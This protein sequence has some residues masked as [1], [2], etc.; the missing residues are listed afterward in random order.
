MG[1]PRLERRC[2]LID[3]REI[4][5][6]ASELSLALHVVEKD[7]VLGWLLAGIASHTELAASWV[8][9]G[10]TCVKKCYF[11]TYR[12]SEDLD[13]TVTD[14]SQLNEYYLLNAFREIADWIYEESGIAIPA[15]QIRF[16]LSVFDGGR[17]AEVRV[18]Y[19]GPL[20]QKRNLA[21]IK[22]DLTSKERLVL[23]PQKRPV[24]HPYSDRPAAGIHVLSYCF[25]E[26]FAEKLRA[27][28]QRERPRDSYDVV[29]L[30]RHDEIRPDRVLLL[31]TL[32][33]K[34]DFKKPLHP[35]KN[36]CCV[37]T[38]TR[39]W[40]LNGTICSRI[41]SRR[42]HHWRN[43][44]QKFLSYLIGYTAALKSVCTKVC[45]PTRPLMQDGGHQPWFMHG[46]QPC[47]WSPFDLRLQTDCA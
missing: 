19:V 28:A 21:R 33:Q 43:F 15:D 31:R 37:S 47:H 10:G 26:V 4:S 29:H 45:P 25:E 1:S 40:M 11:E 44:G 8:F 38:R 12:F 34:C 13:F 18:F 27:L 5:D 9:K 36:L 2:H 41:N 17:Y 39:N 42:F 6:L 35:P 46:G 32:Q 22:F 16:K 3:K 20:Q 14:E 30:F 24:H 23:A 7:Y